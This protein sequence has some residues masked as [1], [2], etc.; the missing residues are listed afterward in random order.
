MHNP[1]THFLI[2]DVFGSPCGWLLHGREA[3]DL[4]QVVLHD[5][6]DDAKLVEVATPP[7]G[8]EG[9]FEG[10]GDVGNGVAIP[11]R[12]ECGVSKPEEIKR[13]DRKIKQ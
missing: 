12:V 13:K 4:E 9:L 1:S 2:T 5:V 8:A 6:T 7:L 10:N 11:N 3:Q